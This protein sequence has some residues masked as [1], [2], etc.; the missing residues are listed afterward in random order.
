TCT[1]ITAIQVVSARQS[2]FDAAEP[3]GGASPVAD[4]A[5]SAKDPAAERVEFMGLDAAKSERPDLGEARVIVSG[6]RA[7]K[8]RF[9]EV[10]DR[11]ALLLRAPS[12]AR[13]PP[14]CAA[15]PGRARAACAAGYA[16]AE[17]QVGQTGR[18]VA[19]RLY[20]A[21]GISGAIQ[22]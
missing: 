4:V 8:E 10:L 6:G 9:A 3:S 11:L 21:I 18:V 19:P 14:P 20:F 16:P 1:I 15:G 5:L 7:L 13:P 22:H 12:A 2:E 17:C